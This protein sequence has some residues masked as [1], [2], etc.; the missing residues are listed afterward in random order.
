MKKLGEFSAI[1]QEEEGVGRGMCVWVW[2]RFR[3]NACTRNLFIPNMRKN[4]IPLIILQ[5]VTSVFLSFSNLSV[6]SPRSQ[7]I[8]Q[9]FLRFTYVTAHSPTLPLLHLRHRSFSNLSFASPTSQ[10]LHVIHLASRPCGVYK[11]NYELK[12]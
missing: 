8:L 11:K 2:L 7:L 3:P 6:T 4:Q 1:L 9:H 5:F 12:R 10:T